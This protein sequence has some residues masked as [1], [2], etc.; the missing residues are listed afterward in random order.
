MNFVC[1]DLYSAIHIVIILRQVPPGLVIFLR[2]L[3]RSPYC[4]LRDSSAVNKTGLFRQFLFRLQTDSDETA[5]CRN[6]ACPGYPAQIPALTLPEIRHAAPTELG[7]KL[8]RIHYNQ[9]NNI[10]CTASCQEKKM[11]C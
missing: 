5:M 11:P 4:V 7:S 8:P 10:T 9:Q 3:N 1:S 2:I 6:H